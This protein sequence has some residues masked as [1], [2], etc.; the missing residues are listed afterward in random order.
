VLGLDQ[1]VGGEPDRIG[2]RVG[3]DDA[4]GGAEQHHR[5][6]AVALHL[7][8][9]EGDRR[10]AGADDLAHLRGDAFGA[11]AERGDAGRPVDAEH[12]AEAELA[13]HHEHRRVDRSA[14]AR[15]GRDHG[16]DLRDPGDQR[17]DGQLVGDARVARLARRREQPGRAIGLIFSPTVRPGSLSNDQSSRARELVLVERAQVGDRIVDRGVDLGARLRRVDLVVVDAQPVGLTSMPSNRA[18]ASH[19][20]SSPRTR[21][22]SISAPIDSRSSGSKMSSSPGRTAPRAP[23]VH[24]RPTLKPQHVGRS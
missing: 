19:T 14:A 10:R 5:A 9:G 2:G 13:A 1:E 4:L 15:H 21:T 6:H 22:S 16:D 12:V 7:D 23:G 20:A 17:R 8:L 24:L 18:S 11:E 3:D